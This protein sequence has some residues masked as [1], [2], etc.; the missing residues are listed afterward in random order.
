MNE[1]DRYIAEVIRIRRNIQ[2]LIELFTEDDSRNVLLSVAGEVFESINRAM[3]DEIIMSVS[4]L[5]DSDSYEVKNKK[6]EYLSQ[7][8]LVSK[9]E[10]YLNDDLR[11]LREETT[12]LLTE[13]DIKNYRDLIIAHNDKATLIGQSST[14]KHNISSDKI[15]SLL[16][17]SMRLM[18]GIKSSILNTEQVSILSNLNEKYVGKGKDLIEKLKKI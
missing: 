15:L 5:F 4:R 1:I 10:S 2:L 3:H 8:N 14:V 17:T 13:I 16:D 6:L 18:I 12:R 9:Y 7:R 11:K